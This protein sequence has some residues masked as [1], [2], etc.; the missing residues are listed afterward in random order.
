[1]NGFSIDIHIRLQRGDDDVFA[2]GPAA[3]AFV[4]HAEGLSHPSGIA[5]KDLQLSPMARA[6]DRLNLP[7][8]GFGISSRRPL[9]IA[10]AHSFESEWILIDGHLPADDTLTSGGIENPAQGSTRGR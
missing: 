9:A 5:Q 2:A 8:Q 1:H 10:G 3:S 4:E 7:Q 6:F